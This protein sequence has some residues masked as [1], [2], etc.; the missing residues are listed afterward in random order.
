MLAGNKVEVNKGPNAG[1]LLGL[2]KTPAGWGITIGKQA[3]QAADSS[4]AI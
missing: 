3:L 1:K 4:A 2:S